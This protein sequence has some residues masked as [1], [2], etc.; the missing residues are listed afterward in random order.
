MNLQ[1]I[2][3]ALSV[4]HNE[5]KCNKPGMPVVLWDHEYKAQWLSDLG[6]LRAHSLKNWSTRCVVQT[7]YFSGKAGSWRFPSESRVRWWGW[8][9]QRVCITAFSTHFHVDTFSSYFCIGVTQL[10]C[11]FLSEEIALCV[12]VTLSLWEEKIQEPPMS[13]SWSRVP[14]LW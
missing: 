14:R 4:K 13:P 12:A 11:G 6:V 10:V 9:L 3:T 8:D 7:I 2:K 1:F 5:V